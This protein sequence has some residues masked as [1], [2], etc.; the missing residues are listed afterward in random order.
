VKAGELLRTAEPFNWAS[1][2]FCTLA[3]SCAD[4][5][6]ATFPKSKLVG[7]TIRAVVLSGRKSAAAKTFGATPVRVAKRTRPSGSVARLWIGKTLVI[8]PGGEAPIFQTPV[9]G[10]KSSAS[11]LP[12]P[13]V[14]ITIKRTRPSWSLAN[15]TGRQ[16]AWI[17]PH[18]EYVVGDH[19]SVKESKVWLAV[20]KL[21]V[22]TRVALPTTSAFPSDNRVLT[23]PPTAFEAVN[24][25][26]PVRGS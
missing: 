23:A 21:E 26:V 4:T 25:H 10:S 24:T 18:V 7:V 2:L 3:V 16:V 20:T 6:I 14:S 15:A 1:P 8:G 19:V 9:V 5:P 13:N 22:P 12:M 11:L 17:P